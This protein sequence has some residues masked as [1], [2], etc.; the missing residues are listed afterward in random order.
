MQKSYEGKKEIEPGLLYI[1]R[2]AEIAGVPQGS[3]T[4]KRLTSKE[5]TISLPKVDKVDKQSQSGPQKLADV[6]TG[7]HVT[8]QDHI[9]LLKEYNDRLY[10]LLSSNLGNLQEGQRTMI[11]YQKAWID[12]YSEKES[13]G[14][15]DKIAEIAYRMGKR[16]DDILSGDSLSGIQTGSDTKG[17]G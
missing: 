7:A 12:E 10:Y 4:G 15:P 1:E 2:L 17:K 14:D 11:A 9:D 16:V 6:L 3:L 13:A 5:I 8:L